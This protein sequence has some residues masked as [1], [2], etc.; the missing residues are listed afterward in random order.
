MQVQEAPAKEHHNLFPS[1]QGSENQH[2]FVSGYHQPGMCRYREAPV[3]EHHNLFPSLQKV[4]ISFVL[5][6]HLSA[7]SHQLACAGT[8]RHLLRDF[9]TCFQASRKVKTSARRF[10]TKYQRLP[11]ATCGSS[12]KAKSLQGRNRSPKPYT[13]LIL[14]VKRF[15][16]TSSS[17]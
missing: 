11:S 10:D 15:M 6:Q 5:I 4:K 1:L 12:R 17:F 14:K 2:R 8:E 13:N 3:K 16:I 7:V 9:T